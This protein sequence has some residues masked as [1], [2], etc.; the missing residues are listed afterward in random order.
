[1]NPPQAKQ[2][3]KA[4]QKK[5]N[6]SKERNRRRRLQTEKV[7]WTKETESSSDDDSCQRRT[8]EETKREDIHWTKETESFSDEIEKTPE[9]E[10]S[11][12]QR[13]T[14]MQ[15]VMPDRDLFPLHCCSPFQCAYQY[16]FFSRFFF[17]CHRCP[18]IH[19]QAHEECEPCV[20][21]EQ[22]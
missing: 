16:G 2:V 8:K 14:D 18:F 1:M 4:K 12:K 7:P 3:L 6:G 17:L 13:V 21:T 15:T 11:Y 22:T 19:Y 9:K 20:P 10:E 5:E